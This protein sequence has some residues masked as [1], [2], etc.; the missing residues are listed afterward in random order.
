M[1]VSKVFKASFKGVSR[2]F[3]GCFKEDGVSMEFLV[4]FKGV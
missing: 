3:Q 2:T 4:G 1:K